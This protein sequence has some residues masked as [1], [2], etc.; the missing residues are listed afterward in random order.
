MSINIIGAGLAGLSAA[1]TLAEQNIPCNLVS[2]APSER[3]QSVMAEGGINA[4]LD[5]AGEHDTIEEHY[6]DTIKGGVYLA[7]E[8]AVWGLC[9]HAPEIVT[10]LDRLGVPFSHN[11][12]G[13]VQ[14]YFGGQKKK[15]TAYVKASTGKMLVTA[16]IDEVRKYEVKGLITRYPRHRFVQLMLDNGA[17]Q[18][19]QIADRI[20]GEPIMLSGAVIIACGGMAGLFD[21]MTT[22]STHNTSDVTATLFAQGV[23]L[24]NLEFVQYHPTTIGIS[25]KRLLISEAARGEGGRLFVRRNSEP[26]YFM[27][28]KYPELKNLMPRDVVSAEMVVVTARD[29]CE[30]QVYLDM[31]AIEKKVWKTR[32]SDLRDQCVHYIAVD[33][34]KEPIPVSPGIHY[35]MGGIRVDESHRTNLHNLYAAGE[36]ACQYHGANRLGGNS[37]LGAIYGGRVAAESVM[38]NH[39]EETDIDVQDTTYSEVSPLLAERISTILYRALPIMRNESNMKAAQQELNA[40]LTPNLNEAENRRLSLA[41]AMVRSAIERKESRGAHKRVDYPERDDA[42][43]RKQSVVR[44]ENGKITLT[45]RDIPERRSE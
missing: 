17:C 34:M 6:A 13:I 15:R 29:D 19:V 21:G 18:G 39:I 36:C 41:L 45:L 16:L 20:T 7:D 35:F 37:L 42:S 26:W 11:D 3:S 31:T 28:E 10:K 33:P 23:E 24:S 9:S 22:G 27:E 5:T 40:M 1:L 14:R 2:Y 38:K 8:N 44:C 32:L 30:D 4:A 12:K 25:G 43:F